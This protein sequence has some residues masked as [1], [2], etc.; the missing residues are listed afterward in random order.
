[1][2]TVI[3]VQEN[4]A[5]LGFDVCVWDESWFQGNPGVHLRGLDKYHAHSALAD[6]VAGYR[7]AGC[8][9]EVNYTDESSSKELGARQDDTDDWEFSWL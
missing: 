7:A 6:L 4:P 3:H 5:P 2:I 9:V 1:M 8:F